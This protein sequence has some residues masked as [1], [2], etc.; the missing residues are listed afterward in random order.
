[1]ART[2]A[3]DGSSMQDSRPILKLDRS[4]FTTRSRY[5]CPNGHSNWEPTNNHI[6]CQSC[7]RAAAQGADVEAE[8]WH[9]V[10]EVTDEEIAWST[11]DL[12]A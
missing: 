3:A 11:V 4:K 7:S 1:M 5:R 2:K 6:W 12:V 10:D 8:H 9:I